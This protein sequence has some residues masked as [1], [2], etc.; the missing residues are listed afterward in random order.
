MMARYAIAFAK[1]CLKM[2][3]IAINV[4]NVEYKPQCSFTQLIYVCLEQ[5]IHTNGQ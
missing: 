1:L 4:I 3:V 5:N 2:I